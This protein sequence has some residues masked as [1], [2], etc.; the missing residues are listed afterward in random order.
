MALT[1]PA[2]L[3]KHN[4]IRKRTR[5]LWGFW[6][7]ITHGRQFVGTRMGYRLLFDLNGIVDRYL[8]A[9]GFYEEERRVALFAAAE[10]AI[11]GAGAPGDRC[12]FLDIGAHWGIYALW[13]QSSGLF[14]RVVAVEADPR[15]AA[16]L[17]ANLYLNDLAG[18]IDV[19]TAAAG[20]ERGEISFSLADKFSRVGSRVTS[21]DEASPDEKITVPAIPMDEIETL[22]GGVLVAK[23]D[24]E[25][26]ESAV[27]KGMQ[28]LLAGNRCVLQIEVFDGEAEAFDASMRALGYH[29]FAELGYDRYYRND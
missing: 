28:G 24:V 18:V 21:T 27:I 29:K 2:F 15:N 8:L 11:K 14:D 13:A 19:Y 5:D 26:F 25:G 17:H 12:V 16:Q 7:L 22:R 1:A 10:D 20:A 6:Y 9:F 4:Y 3:M 23:I